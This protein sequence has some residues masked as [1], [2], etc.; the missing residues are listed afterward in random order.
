M[1]ESFGQHRIRSEKWIHFASRRRCA[2][3]DSRPA[4][5]PGVSG[6]LFARGDSV[7][8]ESALARTTVSPARQIVLRRDLEIMA[9]C[10]ATNAVRHQTR[11]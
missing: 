4:S 1:L 7:I 10:D 2:I 6:I 11:K 3:A 9:D 8:M 5:L